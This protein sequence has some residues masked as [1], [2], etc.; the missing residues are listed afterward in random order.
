ML[1]KLGNLYKF[2][3]K[4]GNR[5]QENKIPKG[6]APYNKPKQKQLKKWPHLL[7]AK[8]FEWVWCLSRSPSDPFMWHL[9]Q[10]YCYCIEL[11]GPYWDKSCYLRPP[12]L[13]PTPKKERNIDIYH[14]EHRSKESPTKE[15]GHSWDFYSIK[16]VVHV[17]SYI[18]CKHQE[19]C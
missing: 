1:L 6:W 3:T 16:I 2:L 13:P 18:N 12:L 7:V 15:Y 17:F 14:R 4:M 19:K 11:Q 10:I 5:L 8:F 9:Y